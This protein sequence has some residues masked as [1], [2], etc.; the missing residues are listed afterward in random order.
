M[1]KPTQMSLPRLLKIRDTY[2][3]R[4]TFKNKI[5]NHLIRGFLN[6]SPIGTWAGELCTAGPVL[7]IA[8]RWAVSLVSTH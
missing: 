6:I 4:N 2:L 5:K 8:G 7:C 1:S 3:Q